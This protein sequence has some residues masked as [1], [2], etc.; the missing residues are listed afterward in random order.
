MRTR[1]VR[2]PVAAEVA[3]AWEIVSAHLRPTPLDVNAM[4][5]LKLESA[6][7][8]GSF[9]VRGAL[10]AMSLAPA[11]VDIVTASAGNHGLG[12]AYAARLLDRRATVVVPGNASP[13]KVSALRGYG[14][15]LVEVGTSYDEAEEHALRLA[16]AGAYFLSPYNDP[17]V[18]AGQGT[19]GHELA[20]QTAGPLTVVCAVGGGGLAA[21]LALWASTRDDVRVVGVEAAVSTALSAS[22]RAGGDVEVSVGDSI[23]D[24]IL[25]NLERGSVTVGIIAEHVDSLVTVTED[26]LHAAIRYLVAQRGV[27]AEGAG[28]AAV[29][30]LLAGKV[31]VTG[32][33]VA[34]V[35][36]RNIALPTL[37]KILA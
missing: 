13:A 34:V 28:A 2:T 32:Q 5:A 11:D 16:E 29:A 30:A 24:G 4:P 25:G 8:V 17:D 15:E 19:I 1:E 22:V 26:E 9:K 20:A 3:K 6:Q 10:T 18:I 36:G 12:V 27:V 37:A 21:G 33:A 7:P 35:S 31:D 23:A 14:V